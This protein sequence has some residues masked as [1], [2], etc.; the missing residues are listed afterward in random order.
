M[1]SQL[2][3]TLFIGVIGL[4]RLVE[5]VLTRRNAAWSFS[6]GGKE[7]GQ[8]HYPAMV[9]LHTG[10]LLACPLE[11]WLLSRPFPALGWW[12]LALALG[13]QILR[14]WCITTLGRRWNTRVI[15]VPGLKRVAGG[16][17]RFMDH[18]NYIAVITEGIAL[19]LIHGAWL[20]AVIFSVLNAWILGVRL[21]CEEAALDEME[22]GELHA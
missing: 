16:P 20:T 7:Y 2:L 12:M 15:I 1:S 5:L 13:A 10:F 19:P 4:E 14:W 17:Y 18:P 21:R 3:Y 22:K 9:V 6:E 8:G 11:V